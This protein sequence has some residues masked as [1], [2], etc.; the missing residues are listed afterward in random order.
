MTTVTRHAYKNTHSTAGRP[1]VH[2]IVVED[3]R[4]I[5]KWNNVY[6]NPNYYF[7]MNDGT[8]YRLVD[9]YGALNDLGILNYTYVNS[10]AEA[11]RADWRL[12]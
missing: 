11:R 9:D 2:E 6:G 4:D 8:Y 12:R 5:Y 3:I 10:R 1:D 7:V